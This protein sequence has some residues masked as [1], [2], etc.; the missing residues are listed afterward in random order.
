MV[1]YEGA[2]AFLE[3]GFR[4]SCNVTGVSYKPIPL[5]PVLAAPGAALRLWEEERTGLFPAPQFMWL[6]SGQVLGLQHLPG[7]PHFT[8][9]RRFCLWRRV[10]RPWLA[11]GKRG[12]SWLPNGLGLLCALGAALVVPTSL[13]PPHKVQVCRLW[14]LGLSPVQSRSPHE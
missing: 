12:N 9:E 14:S 8:S 1:I 5:A 11:R 6:K 10:G 3:A 13:F 4:V 2:N 7:S